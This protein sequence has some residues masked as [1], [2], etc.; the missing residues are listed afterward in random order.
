MKVYLGG[1]YVALMD[2]IAIHVCSVDLSI[3]N[4]SQWPV[5]LANVPQRLKDYSDL[6]EVSYAHRP[7]TTN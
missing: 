2:P 3:T 4:A 5:D 6:I 7:V 1:N